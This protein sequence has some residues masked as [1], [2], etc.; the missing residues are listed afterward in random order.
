MILPEE[1]FKRCHWG[2]CRGGR[3]RG[4]RRRGRPG[5]VERV[6]VVIARAF[7]PTNADESPVAAFS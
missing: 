7:L 3:S 2:P 4:S 6:W 5:R 1:G